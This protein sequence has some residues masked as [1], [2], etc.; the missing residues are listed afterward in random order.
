MYVYFGMGRLP[1]SSLLAL[2]KRVVLQART[3][4]LGV[5]VSFVLMTQLHSTLAYVIIETPG[6]PHQ[7]NALRFMHLTS[8]AICFAG[9]RGAARQTVQC[10]HVVTEPDRDEVQIRA[11]PPHTPA[12]HALKSTNLGALLTSHHRQFPILFE[13]LGARNRVTLQYAASCSSSTNSQASALLT[14]CIAL[15]VQQFYLER[16]YCPVHILKSGLNHAVL[17]KL[18]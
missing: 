11:L 5:V 13:A 10:L 2:L 8:G 14:Q 1:A 9:M 18:A 16:L 15:S 3:K 4:M 12:Q 17:T 7:D 6:A